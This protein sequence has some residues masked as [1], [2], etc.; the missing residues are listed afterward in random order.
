MEINKVMLLIFLISF[1]MSC[2]LYFI[3]YFDCN[4]VN[5][6]QINYD[7]DINLNNSE[8][9]INSKNSAELSQNNNIKKPVKV[10]K[11]NYELI[12]YWANWCGICQKI[13]PLWKDAR[14]EIE[15]K[16]NNIIIKEINCD[17]P[18]IDKCH[19]LNN[20]VKRMLD[21]VPTIVLRYNGTDIEYKKED[22]LRGDRS[23]DDIMK[24]LKINL[25]N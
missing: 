6:V 12:F 1:V 14:K 17:N 24:F 15:K 8:V 13:K 7:K 22:N 19:I 4:K 3:F 10:S 16:Y 23:K 18:S 21:G 20:N 11:S 9:T 5:N 25:K 2:L